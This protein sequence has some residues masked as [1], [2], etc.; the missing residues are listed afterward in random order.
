MTSDQQS[1]LEEGHRLDALHRSYDGEAQL[2]E[3]FIVLTFGAGL[4]ATLGL[5][6][7]NAAVVI[8]AMVVAPWILPLR[9]AVFA[10]LSGSPRIL[11]RSMATLAAGAAITV[12]LSMGL[13]LFF[14]ANG[15]L[16]VD[17]LPEQVMARLE[18]TLLDLGIALAAGAIATYAKV[19]PGAVSSMA[20][21][22]IAV[23]LVPPVCVM[24]LMIA[25]ND[26]EAAQGSGLLYLANLLGILIGGLIV[27]AAREPYF[28]DKLR[29]SRRS[30]LPVLLS[31]GLLIFI[32]ENL[33][34][35]YDQ[36]LN[37]IKRE[38]AK[39]RIETEIRSYL[40]RR[41]LTFGANEALQMESIDFDWPDHWRTRAKPKLQLVV[42][43]TD[44]AIPSNKQVQEI[45]NRI[46]TKLSENFPGLQMQMQV[47]RINVSVVS[48]R[49]VPETIDL[50]QILNQSEDIAE[51]SSVIPPDQRIEVE[52][53]P[54]D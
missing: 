15:L 10:L 37:N 40:Y 21:T 20:G 8:G 54:P 4:I 14:R 31:I 6:S 2:N 29:R 12:L 24:G 5:L 16:N 9:V 43:V 7:N 22:A 53:I 50:D 49:D 25:A 11:F 19:N 18:P 45:Q 44:P 34:G 42:R 48:G 1:L 39:R 28:Q 51:K 3:S 17:L 47:L 46:N 27:L 26:L 35:R 33:L 38:A 32:G 36:Y 30:R 13:G 41:T 23:A 52:S